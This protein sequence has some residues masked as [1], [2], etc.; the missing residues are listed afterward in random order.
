MSNQFK[1]PTRRPKCNYVRN[2]T[3]MIGLAPQGGEIHMLDMS[4]RTWDRRIRIAKKAQRIDERM[5][6][7]TFDL[8][9]MPVRMQSRVESNRWVWRALGILER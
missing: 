5:A 6:D 7:A 4:A 8:E 2:R 1:S 9:T 3:T